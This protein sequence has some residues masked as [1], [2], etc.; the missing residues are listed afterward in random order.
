MSEVCE[1]CGKET[2]WSMIDGYLVVV[3]HCD[4]YQLDREVLKEAFEKTM[5]TRRIQEWLE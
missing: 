5:A 3:K 2:K 4:C 1:V